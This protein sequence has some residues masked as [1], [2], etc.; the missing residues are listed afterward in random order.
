MCL[1]ELKKANHCPFS[2]LT[3][4]YCISLENPVASNVTQN[5]LKCY[6]QSELFPVDILTATHNCLVSLQGQSGWETVKGCSQDQDKMA[7]YHDAVIYGQQ[8]R[9]IIAETPHV[10]LNDES[11]AL[12]VYDLKK[13]LCRVTVRG[14]DGCFCLFTISKA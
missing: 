5:F 11:P 2:S 14:K 1:Q 12:A 4:Q 7:N 3:N 8:L 9:P 10:Y 6:F 13:A